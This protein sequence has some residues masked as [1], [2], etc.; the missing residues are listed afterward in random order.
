MSSLERR[1]GREEGDLRDLLMYALHNL[2]IY[3]G[4]TD[5]ACSLSETYRWFRTHILMKFHTQ[6]LCKTSKD[7][8]RTLKTFFCS[9]PEKLGIKDTIYET[10]DGQVSFP[11]RQILTLW[12]P[13]VVTYQSF[14][15]IKCQCFELVAS[16]TSTWRPGI[17]PQPNS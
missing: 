16:P 12:V 4:Q 13:Q 17:A 11:S 6:E 7:F 15:I 8:W 9:L 10:A 2:F 5:R 1:R 3:P 14:W